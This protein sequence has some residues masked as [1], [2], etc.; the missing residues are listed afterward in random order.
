MVLDLES[1]LIQLGMTR[2]RDYEN[3]G[4]NVE[5]RERQ[6]RVSSVMLMH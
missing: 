3:T 1:E 4:E 2:I 6:R 5:G